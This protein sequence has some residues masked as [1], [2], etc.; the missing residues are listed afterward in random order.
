MK[1]SSV[2]VSQYYYPSETG[3]DA[4]RGED[5][6]DCRFSMFKKAKIG[7]KNM[8]TNTDTNEAEYA[9]WA[10]RNKIL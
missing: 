9:Q 6:I 5:K 4:G 8:I 7:S 1:K 10:K 3:Q 2:S